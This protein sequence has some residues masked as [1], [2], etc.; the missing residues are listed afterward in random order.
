MARLFTITAPGI[1][2]VGSTTRP[3]CLFAWTDGTNWFAMRDRPNAIFPGTRFELTT[4]ALLD[5]Q[6]TALWAWAQRQSVPAGYRAK[7]PA[8]AIEIKSEAGS[9]LL[10]APNGSAF[11]NEL[12][13]IEYRQWGRVARSSAHS[14]EALHATVLSAI[15]KARRAWGG[16]V[17]RGL[18]LAFHDGGRNMGTT[19]NSVQD[20][21]TK[22][23]RLIS[24]NRVLVAEYD[25]RAIERTLLHELAHH[26]RGEESWPIKQIA[27]RGHDDRFCSMLAEVDPIVASSPKDCRYFTDDQDESIA[28]KKAEKKMAQSSWDPKAGELFVPK[29]KTT[30]SLIW[31]PRFG[32]SFREVRF[33]FSVEDIITLLGQFDPSEWERVPVVW[34][35][36]KPSWASALGSTDNL[37]GLAVALIRSYPAAFQKLRALLEEGV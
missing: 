26:R 1:Q 32:Q 4:T 3:C 22:S 27:N 18:V 7:T 9:P 11:R 25:L 28:E 34:G 6:R 37:A 8:P 31:R 35:R 21:K 29:L 24:L 13:P 16:W 30:L 36:S 2:G 15:E 14:L 23:E 20:P 33:K 12:G 17:P 19:F 10:R 5:P